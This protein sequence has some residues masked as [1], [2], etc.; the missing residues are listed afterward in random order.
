MA[1]VSWDY[2]KLDEN[3]EIQHAPQNDIDGSITGKIVIGLKQYFDE[4]PIERIRLG[5]IK[6]IWGDRKSVEYNKQSQYLVSVQERVD[7]YTVREVFRVV[8]KSEEQMLL[9]ELL[10]DSIYDSELIGHGGIIF[11]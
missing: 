8:D 11:M 7:P 6:C 4:N 10:G 3:Y 5:W 9:E 1:E 2:R